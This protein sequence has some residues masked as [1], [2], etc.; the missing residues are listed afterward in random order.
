MAPGILFCFVVGYFLLLLV[1]AYLTSRK[2]SDN[3][4]FFIANRNSKWYLV[5]LG[6]IGPSI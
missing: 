5:A 4:T 6:M 1:I 2:S 3:D